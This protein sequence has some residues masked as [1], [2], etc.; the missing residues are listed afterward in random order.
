MNRFLSIFR[1]ILPYL[2]AVAVFL[3]VSAIYLYPTFQGKVLT[4]S[5]T[6]NWKCMANEINEFKAAH[7][8]EPACWTNSSFGGMPAY[9]ISCQYPSN[10]VTRFIGSVHKF[11]SDATHL[12]MKGLFGILMGYF[13]GFLILLLAFG[14]DIWVAIVGSLAITFSSYFMLIIPAGHETKALALGYLA[15]VVGGFKF[16]FNKKYP[17]GMAIVMLYCS[18]GITLHPQMTYYIFM[19]MALF[20]IAEIVIHVKEKRIRD[21]FISLACFLVAVVVGLGSRFMETVS[22]ME[23]VKES[24]R[25]GHSDIS[26]AEDGKGTAG[27]DGTTS[28][29][30][31]LEYATTWSY[32][33]DE[34]LTFLVPNY[35]GGEDAYNAGTDSYIYKSMVEKGVSPSQAREIAGN[36]PLYWGDQP[37]TAGPVYMGALAMLLFVIG[38]MVYKGPYKWALVAATLMS[39]LLSFGYHFMPLTKLFF[40]YFPLYNKFRTVSSILV[41]AEITIPLLGFLGLQKIVKGEVEKKELFKAIKYAVAILGGILLCLLAFSYIGSFS[42]PHDN[43]KMGG[44]PEWFQQL[45]RDQRSIMLRKDALRSLLFVAA[46]AVLLWLYGKQKVKKPAFIALLGLLVLVD[47]IPVSFRF[48]GE[49]DYHNK[50]RTADHTAIQPYEELILRDN[51]PYF[52]VFNLSANAFTEA[53]TSFRLKSLGGYHAAKL[54]RYND[55]IEYHLAMREPNE[56]VINMLNTKYLLVKSEGMTYPMVNQGA[57]GNGWFVDKVNFVATPKEESDALWTLDLNHEAV[58]DVKF[59]DVAGTAATSE[60]DPDAHITLT[61][62]SPDILEYNSYSNVEKVAVFSDIYYPYGWKAYVDGEPKE[63]FRVNYVLRAM[64]IPAGNHTIRF[65]FRPDSLF[66]GYHVNAACRA[67]ILLFIVGLL[68]RSAIPLFR[69]KAD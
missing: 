45:V 37:F 8:D 17:L 47:M 28:K 61:S 6:E 44:M 34:T 54:R 21:L 24:I 42:G 64:S 56:N 23:Y 68:M 25:G 19:M 36:L 48:F 50:V 32:G 3:A 39:L 30:L 12:W 63:H 15:A 65:E 46:G 53:R 43:T 13:L 31:S 22:N 29:G 38:L 2:V 52:R 7:P 62:Y 67:I 59:R 26:D 60:P 20:G 69:R 66:K 11:F 18:I 35:M 27:A 33:I 57:M 5:D 14:V 51:D 1:K 58:S 16:I 41:V 55:L 9:Q 49:S 4:Q 10:G 40:N